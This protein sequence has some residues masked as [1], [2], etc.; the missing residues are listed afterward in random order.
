MSPKVAALEFGRLTY[1]RAGAFSMCIE[2][3]FWRFHKLRFILH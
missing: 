2:T 1:L 3:V